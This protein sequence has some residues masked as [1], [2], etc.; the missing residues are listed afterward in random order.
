LEKIRAGRMADAA[1]APGAA[2]GAD[3]GIADGEAAADGLSFEGGEEE[4]PVEDVAQ[5]VD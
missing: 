5:D 3:G 1:A 2:A 4:A